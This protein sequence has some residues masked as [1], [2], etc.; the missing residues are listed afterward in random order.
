MPLTREQ[1][2][3]QVDEITGKLESATTL[4]LTDYKGLTVDQVNDLRRRFR[5]SGVE[6]K[7]IKNTLLRL[8][9]E[10]LGGFD[11]LYDHLNGPTAV[12]MSEEPAAPARVIK[13][14][15]KARETELPALKVAYVDGA[16]YAGD[17]LD[18]LASLKSKDELL[19]DILGLLLS[20]MTNVVS[21][22]QAQGTNLA[23]ILQSIA[24]KDEAVEG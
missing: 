4:Y 11:D 21:A 12:A 19:G 2:A 9:M 22:L 23:A 6:Y 24:E 13:E 5:A 3:T 16:L 18:M 1:K 14:F 15:T 17:Q 8:A 10:R 7:V 20:P